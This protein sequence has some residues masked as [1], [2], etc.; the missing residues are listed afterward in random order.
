MKYLDSSRISKL[1][2]QYPD[3]FPPLS[4]R[5]VGAGQTVDSGYHSILRFFNSET[6]QPE[7]IT[8]RVSPEPFAFSDPLV[9]QF[10]AYIADRLTRQGRLYDGPAVSGFR[11][12]SLEGRGGLLTVQQT[13]YRDFAGSL[14]ALDLPYPAFARYGGTLRDY[15]LSAYGRKPYEQR[16]LANCLGVCGHLMV[17]ENR[18]RFLLQVRRAGRLAT[19]PD[20]SGP[21]A[22]GSVDFEPDYTSVRDLLR[23]ALGQEVR[24]ELMLADREFEI[25]PLAFAREI[26]R[27]DNP[28]LFGLIRTDLSRRDVIKRLTAIPEANREFSE[29]SFQPLDQ[30][31]R[32]PVAEIECLNFEA[33]M[34][35]YLLEEYLDLV[36]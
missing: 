15:Y 17:E 1:L 33:R 25:I 9:K 29:F 36:S 14:F 30:T 26:F 4:E 35:Y 21:S 5:L 11:S 8:V 32:L 19:L 3:C 22:A 18:Q 27:G 13:S 16:P 24:E 31:G 6:A 12:L 28:Q 2:Q 34:S 7:S 23:R 10:A 20:T